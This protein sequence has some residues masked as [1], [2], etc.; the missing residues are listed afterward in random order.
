MALDLILCVKRPFDNFY[1]INIS[2][3]GIYLC[4]CILC[5]VQAKL[6]SWLLCAI[7]LCKNV[8]VFHS[9][10]VAIENALRL[11]SPRLAIVDEHLSRHLPKQWLTSLAIEVCL[12]DA[13]VNMSFYVF[14]FQSLVSFEK[15][16]CPFIFLIFQ[17][18]VSFEK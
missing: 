2:F 4:W 7:F 18:L 9:R 15:K 14:N 12:C 13:F 3:F 6:H 11:F 8:I 1:I 16:M 5:T 10:D 17:A